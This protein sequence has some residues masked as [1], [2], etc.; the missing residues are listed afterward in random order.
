MDCSPPGSAI[1]GSSRQEYWSGLPCPAPGD[2]SNLGIEPRSPTLQAESLL[3]ELQG[4]PKLKVSQSYL[5][6]CDPMNHTVHGVPQAR[7]LDWVTS[8]LFQRIFPTQELN[9]GLLHCRWILYQLSYQGSPPETLRVLCHHSCLL[10]PFSYKVICTYLSIECLLSF[11]L[12][13]LSA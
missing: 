6:L 9:W 7:I 1:H 13:I 11:I 5:T 10:L 4:K 8:S 3:P 2:L 12:V